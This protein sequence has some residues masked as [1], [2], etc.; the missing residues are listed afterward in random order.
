MNNSKFTA[1]KIRSEY[2]SKESTKVEQLKALD[3]KVKKPI[4]IFSYVFGSIYAIIM[5]S[6]MSLVMTD[7]GKTIGLTN[8]LPIG[9]AVG[10]IGLAGA[11]LNYPIHKKLMSARRKKFS[12]EIIAL[13][14]SI[15]NE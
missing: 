4:N 11:I 15:I 9:I 13:S 10:V 7:L 12:S 1:E 5:G 6:G 2:V 14:E 8:A 3:A